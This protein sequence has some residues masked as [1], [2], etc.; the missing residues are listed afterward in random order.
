MKTIKWFVVLSL[1]LAP[2]MVTSGPSARAFTP[3]DADTAMIC[4]GSG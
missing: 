4:G 2:I 1:A 3:S